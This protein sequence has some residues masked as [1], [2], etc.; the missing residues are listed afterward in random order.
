MT[1]RATVADIGTDI[2]SQP[3]VV[4][5]VPF[6]TL[7]SARSG[8]SM[9]AA[10]RSS[11]WFA[12]RTSSSWAIVTASNAHEAF[13][14]I[15]GGHNHFLAWA[16]EGRYVYTVRST[17]NVQEYDIWRE[18]IGG[19]KPQRVTHTNAAILHAGLLDEDT[20]LYIAPDGNGAGPWLFALD[21]RRGEEHRVSIGVEQY[22]SIGVGAPVSGSRRRLATVLPDG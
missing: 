19:G 9:A 18:P 14:E 7:G 3:S 12:F 15:P 6:L 5:F 2:A 20:L 4:P 10:W 11:I 22:A 21:L 16:P 8:L 17:Q 13:P 1:R